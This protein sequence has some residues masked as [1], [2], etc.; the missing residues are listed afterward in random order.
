MLQ[1]KEKVV[2]SRTQV[3]FLCAFLLVNCRGLSFLHLESIIQ[4]ILI[5]LKAQCISKMDVSQHIFKLWQLL[6]LSNS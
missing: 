3:S 1:I 6:N 2:F 4:C 5:N